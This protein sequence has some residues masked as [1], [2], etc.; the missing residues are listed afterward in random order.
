MTDTNLQL[1]IFQIDLTYKDKQKNLS[2]I[3]SLANNITNTDIILLPEM[4]NTSFITNDTSLAEAMDGPTITWMQKL[5][6]KKKASVAGT[7][8]VK[9]KGYFYNRLVWVRK[10]QT[11]L[12]YDKYHLFSLAKEDKIFTKGKEKII[13]NEKGWNICPLICYDIRFPVFCRNK[14]EYD[15][16]IFLS[17]WPEKR[18]EAW[19]TLL[20]ARAIENQ[21]Y[22]IGAN[23]VGEHENGRNTHGE[24]MIIDPWGKVLATQ[25]MGV[26][27]VIAD[28]DLN[29]LSV[30]REEFPVWSHRKIIVNK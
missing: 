30:L 19:D 8:I 21:C 25:N 12:H 16:L 5:A 2:N 14:E 3:D 29:Y 26:G 10:D 1:S 13:I 27:V 9:D 18:I 20:K 11:L 23:Q 24:S 15:V 17:S 4:F 28:I 7:L 6:K 22:M